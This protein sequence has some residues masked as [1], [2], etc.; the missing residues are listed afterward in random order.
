[1]TT[2]ERPRRSSGTI[3]AQSSSAS[4]HPRTRATASLS[5][6][7]DQSGY[8]IFKKSKSPRIGVTRNG[9]RMESVRLQ[10]GTGR[11]WRKSQVLLDGHPDA[12]SP[13]HRA[14]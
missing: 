11:Q 1:M 3:M 10:V 4:R 6:A 7:V 13:T 8:S 2:E 14:G 12:Q 9:I 5:R